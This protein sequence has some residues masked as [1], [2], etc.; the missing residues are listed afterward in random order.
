MSYNSVVVEKVNF[1]CY[2]PKSP[3]GDLLKSSDLESPPWG[4]WG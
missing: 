3:K 4:V 1:F 2:T